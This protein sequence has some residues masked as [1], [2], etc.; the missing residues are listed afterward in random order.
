LKKRS[1]GR[2]ESEAIIKTEELLYSYKITGDTLHLDEYFTLPAGRKWAGDNVE[3]N[4]NVPSGT[5]V[6]FE[7]NPKILLHAS[8]RDH[9]EEYLESR[10][11]SNNDSWVMTDDGLESLAE[12]TYKHK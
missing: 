8:F 3:I 5:V 1:S 7:H 4:L 2:T 10:W 12:G 6:K 9:S 11:E